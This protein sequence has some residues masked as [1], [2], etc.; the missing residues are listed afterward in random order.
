M[1]ATFASTSTLFIIIPK[2]FFPQQDTGAHQ[3]HRSRERRIFLSTRCRRSRRNSAISCMADPAVSDIVAYVGGGAMNTGRMIIELEA[4]RERKV[5]ADQVIARLR[6]E[7]GGGARSARC[8]FRRSGHSAWAAESSNSQYQYTLESENLADLQTWA[9]RMLEQA[10]DAA[11]I[12]RRVHRSAGSRAC[13]R[14]LVIDRDTA[15]RLGIPRADD[16]QHALRRVWPA[17]GL[18]RLH[19]IERISS[20]DG[21][22][23]EFQQNPDALE[24][25]LREVVQR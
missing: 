11:G 8:F 9:P 5:S 20:R 16:R 23:S 25:H 22:G 4:A 24:E 3:R 6:Q 2:G 15:S 13:K 18:H 21:S 12:A 17:A 10:E 1:I 19:A 7:T 14:Q